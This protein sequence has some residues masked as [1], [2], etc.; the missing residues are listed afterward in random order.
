MN[1]TETKV[2]RFRQD[3]P[4]VTVVVEDG[5]INLHLSSF[6]NYSEESFDKIVKFLVEVN[7]HINPTK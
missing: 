1:L 4:H 2:K 5:K 3:N 7:E 6:T